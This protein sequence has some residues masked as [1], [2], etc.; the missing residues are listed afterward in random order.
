MPELR[1]DEIGSSMNSCNSEA[2]DDSIACNVMI[3]KAFP[4][5]L[6]LPDYTFGIRQYRPYLGNV[7]P[8]DVDHC[9]KSNGSV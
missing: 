2:D 4:R 1:Y 5:R 8:E 6:L 7:Y 3:R 9:E